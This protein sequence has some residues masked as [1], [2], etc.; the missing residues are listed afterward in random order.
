MTGPLLRIFISK[1]VAE[2]RAPI[3]KALSLGIET[4]VSRSMTL[5]CGE[6]SIALDSRF[7]TNC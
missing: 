5:P 6:A 1:N 4:P 7:N 3:F 2:S